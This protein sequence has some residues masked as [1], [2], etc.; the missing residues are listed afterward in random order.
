[1]GKQ[2]SRFEDLQRDGWARQFIANEPRLSEAVELY[3]QTGFEVHLESIPTK[4][5]IDRCPQ[6]EAGECRICFEGNENQYKIIYTR[7]KDDSAGLDDELF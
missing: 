7:P 5:E 2:T 4:D 3:E 6:G 1:M